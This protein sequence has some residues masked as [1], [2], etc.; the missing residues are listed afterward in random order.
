MA[1]HGEVLRGLTMGWRIYPS[2]DEEEK[3]LEYLF[4]GLDVCYGHGL[5]ALADAQATV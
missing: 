5:S 4:I 2:T 1:S 3:A